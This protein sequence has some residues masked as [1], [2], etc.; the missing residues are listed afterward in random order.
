MKMKKKYFPQTF[1]Q[2]LILIFL[3]ILLTT[4][5]LFINR[6]KIVSEYTFT[7]IFFIFFVFFVFLIFYLKNRKTKKFIL[8]NFKV[9]KT[10]FLFI[11]FLITFQL[12][13]N[14][15]INF[16]LNS[17]INGNSVNVIKTI[18]T[19]LP[20]VFISAFFE[21][22]IFR[23]I[24]LRGYLFK[25][26]P[27]KAILISSLF[28]SVIH[29]NLAQSLGALFFSFF[30]SY[31]YYYSRSVGMAILLH[32]TNNVIALFG[33][34]LLNSYGNFKINYVNDFYGKNSFLIIIL[35][36]IILFS[37][38]FFFFKNKTKIINNLKHLNDSK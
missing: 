27:K 13:I 6:L 22:L 11:L 20:F 18:T 4:P 16:L 26:S 36:L 8:F 21:E 17:Q 33:V 32:L 28:F 2:S 14:L 23:G 24:I 10:I 34:Y 29:F 3:S 19:T 38:I 37:L 35:S 9:H 1:L 7:H 5:L 15:P 25:Y 31:I 30:V 12:S